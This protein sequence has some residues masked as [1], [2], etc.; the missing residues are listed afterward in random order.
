MCVI[1]SVSIGG[2]F[3]PDSPLR[4]G[5]CACAC[6]FCMRVRVS[7]CVCVCVFCVFEGG[8]Q[9]WG[10]VV[11]GHSR[12]HYSFPF[13]LSIT[14]HQL[15]VDVPGNAAAGAAHSEAFVD[16]VCVCVCLCGCVGGMRR[17]GLV[18]G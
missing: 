5:V 16:V 17:G 14:H 8:T 3:F 4:G 10:P 12:T 6:V 15:T 9:N 18:D 2:L 1:V 13:V 11:W 7:V